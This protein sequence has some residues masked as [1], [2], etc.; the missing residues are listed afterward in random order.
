MAYQRRHFILGAAEVTH[1]SKLRYIVGLQGN[2]AE[3]RSTARWCY[4]SPNITSGKANVS[5]SKS[6]K[7]KSKAIPVTGLEGLTR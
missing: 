1:N 5:D 3:Y 7:K 2:P 6:K 4:N